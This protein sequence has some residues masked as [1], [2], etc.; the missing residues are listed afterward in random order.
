MKKLAIDYIYMI[1]NVKFIKSNMINYYFNVVMGTV[2]DIN[3]IIYNKEFIKGFIPNS[4]SKSDLGYI[5][6]LL[7]ELFVY[8]N[9]QKNTII[10]DACGLS[11]C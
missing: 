3:N 10:D 11:R 9:E 6:V 5:Y 8:R 4:Y 2:H 7:N 1:Y